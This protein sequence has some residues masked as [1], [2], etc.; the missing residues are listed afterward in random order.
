MFNISSFLD[1]FL[2]NIKSQDLYNEG[3]IEVIKKTT[4][5]E[6]K[7]EDL[8]IKDCVL[9]IKSNGAIKNKMFIFKSKI[10]EEINTFIKPN[11]IDI[12]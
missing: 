7:K 12:R 4:G 8:E 9:F 6:L 10:L 5:I 3:V 1:K 2:K 11:L